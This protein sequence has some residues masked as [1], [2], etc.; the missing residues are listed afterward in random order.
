MYLNAYSLSLGNLLG[1]W[2]YLLLSNLVDFKML[3]CMFGMVL[4]SGPFAYDSK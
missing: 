1:D 4:A 3:A 2:T